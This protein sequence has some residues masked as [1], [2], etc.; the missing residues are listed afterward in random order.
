VVDATKN[1]IE[2]IG[3]R[4]FPERVNRDT[5]LFFSDRCHLSESSKLSESSSAI[6]IASNLYHTTD[7]NLWTFIRSII[8]RSKSSAE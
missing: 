2:D 6:L 5:I 8:L 7:L 3:S 4:I 1:K